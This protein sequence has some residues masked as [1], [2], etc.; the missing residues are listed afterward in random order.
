MQRTDQQNKALH[1]YLR[2]LA[3]KLNANGLDMRT[4]L[5]PGVKIAWNESMVKEYLWRPIQVIVANKLS[6]KELTSGEPNRVYEVLQ[7]HL[8]KTF[9]DYDVDVEFPHIPENEQ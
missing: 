2:L 4:V 7:S 9:S 5:K 3:D 8:N 1:F 6:T